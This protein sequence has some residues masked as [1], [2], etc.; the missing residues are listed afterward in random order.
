MKLSKQDA[1]DIL[2]GDNPEYEIKVNKIVD[3]RRWS[4]YYKLVVYHVPSGHYYITGYSTGA[5][6]Q[7]DESPWEYNKEVEFFEAEPFE[8]TTIEYRVKK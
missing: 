5:T 3:H 4:L 1:L 2:D 6:E 7:Q 8:V